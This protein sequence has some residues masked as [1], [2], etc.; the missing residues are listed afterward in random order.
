MV[1]HNCVDT[2]VLWIFA[3]IAVYLDCI[4][5]YLQLGSNASLCVVHG[6]VSLRANKSILTRK[7]LVAALFAAPVNTTTR[8]V[9]TKTSPPTPTHSS[10]RK[11]ENYRRQLQ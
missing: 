6:E 5:T 7:A 8:L 4:D 1:V 10:R 2:I 11:N 3:G 9:G